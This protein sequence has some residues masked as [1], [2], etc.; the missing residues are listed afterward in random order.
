[1]D[2]LAAA[3]AAAL[4]MHALPAAMLYRCRTGPS[5]FQRLASCENLHEIYVS[6]LAVFAFTLIVSEQTNRVLPQHGLRADKN[7]SKPLKEAFHFLDRV[8]LI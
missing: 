2:L 5:Y 8:V 6:A 7:N 3:A 1:M 4:R